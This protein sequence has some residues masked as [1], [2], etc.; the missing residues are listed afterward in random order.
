M[1]SPSIIVQ[2]FSSPVPEVVPL[3]RS[4]ESY[5]SMGRR[6]VRSSADSPPAVRAFERLL[7]R[8]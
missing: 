5:D 2:L 4:S 3:V 6:L 1:Y 7:Y 8:G